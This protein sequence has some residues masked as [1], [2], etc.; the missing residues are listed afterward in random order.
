[1]TREEFERMVCS[2]DGDALDVLEGEIDGFDPCSPFNPTPGEMGLDEDADE[3]EVEEALMDNYLYNFDV[4]VDGNI[5][6]SGTFVVADGFVDRIERLAAYDLKGLPEYAAV[7][8][9]ARIPDDSPEMAVVYDRLA[10][11]LN[12]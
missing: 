3:E 4:E 11:L 8:D 10:K 9:G 7:T 2:L 1:M 12:E 5:G 6:V